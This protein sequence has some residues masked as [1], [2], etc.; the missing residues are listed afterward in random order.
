LEFPSNSALLSS[1][2]PIEEIEIGSSAS[3]FSF[4][5]PLGLLPP[6]RE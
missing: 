6:S 4:K 2:N 1:I 5:A 3:Q